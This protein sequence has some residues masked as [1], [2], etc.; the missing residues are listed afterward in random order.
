MF[1][2]GNGVAQLAV[3]VEAAGEEV[4]EK[5]SANL[6][7]LRDYCLRLRNPLVRPLQHNRD[8]GLLWQRWNINLC[9]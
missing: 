9:L 7:E 3:F 2:V 4:M 5:A 6:L 8:V 1:R